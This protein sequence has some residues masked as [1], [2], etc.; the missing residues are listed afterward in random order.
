MSDYNK[1]GIA[2]MAIIKME[3]LLRSIKM[4][5]EMKNDYSLCEER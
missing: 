3:H 4:K 5:G 2:T 1:D